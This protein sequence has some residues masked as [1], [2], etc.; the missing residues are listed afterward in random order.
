MS[1]AWP[2][3]RTFV[4]ANGKILDAWNGPLQQ[5][6]PLLALSTDDFT[7]LQALIAAAQETDE[8]DA[9]SGT[10]PFAVAIDEEPLFSEDYA[11]G[12]KTSELAARRFPL[13]KFQG[14]PTLISSTTAGGS[15]FDIAVP[16]GYTDILLVVAGLSASSN[17]LLSIG[18]SEDA[19]VTLLDQAVDIFRDGASQAGLVSANTAV[20]TVGSANASSAIYSRTRLFGYTSNGVKMATENTFN[21]ISGSSVAGWTGGRLLTNSVGPIN[22]IRF[23]AAAGSFDAGTVELW[24]LP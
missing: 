2:S 3:D 6:K 12:W 15:S 21:F 10:D 22:A 11:I 16:S 19:G 18:F 23:A 9:V 4:D 8:D 14:V 20:W 17:G 5:L 7:T 24:G 1:K 13:T